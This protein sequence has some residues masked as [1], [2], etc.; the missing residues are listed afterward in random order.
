MIS[1][2]VTLAI[3]GLIVWLVTAYI[4]MPEVF[5][6]VIYVVAVVCVLLFVLRAFGIL[7]STP[8]HDVPVP[9]LVR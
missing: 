3:V 4:P 2:I 8:I 1:L 7:H 6:K 9:Q 5:K